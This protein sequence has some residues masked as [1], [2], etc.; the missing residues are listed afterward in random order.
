MDLLR[1]IKK[2]TSA[3]TEHDSLDSIKAAIRHVEVA[4]RHFNRARD[5][6]EEDLFNDVIYRT[7]QAFEGMLKEAYTVL[8]SNDGNK[9][10][11]NQ[12][13]Q[14][15]IKEEV[16][17]SR[18]L[19]LFKNYRQQ[20]RNPSAHDHKLFFSEQESL[21]AIVSVSAFANI[22]LDQII[23]VINFKREQENVQAIKAQI[24]QTVQDSSS[25]PLYELLIALLKQFSS[26]LLSSIADPKV[27]SEV[28]IIGRLHGF[29]KS[30]D[31]SWTILREP[32]LK[33]GVIEAGN[34]RVLRPD[35]YVRRDDEAAIVE[36]KR[37]GFNKSTLERGQI[38]LINYL[39]VSGLQHG[40]L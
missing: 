2:K 11:P 37:A 30:I 8:T 34:P 24:Q 18:V 28:E 22:L 10:S 12:I 4:E 6:H 14:H 19:E 39:E 25:K 1:E 31:I 16:F 17:A 33:S 7:N 35:L 15:L 38:Q 23:E 32:S 40:I 9:L 29:L 3:I 20:W 13:E 21:L 5:E 27:L 36:V 26:E